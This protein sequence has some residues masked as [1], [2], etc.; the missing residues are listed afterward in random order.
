[1]ENTIIKEKTLIEGGN[2]YES[3]EIEHS[4][5]NSIIAQIG[6]NCKYK[7]VNDLFIDILPQVEAMV[8]EKT[9][10]LHKNN[11][12]GFRTMVDTCVSNVWMYFATRPIDEEGYILVSDKKIEKLEAT[13][14]D[15]VRYKSLDYNRNYSSDSYLN[16]KDLKDKIRYKNI[17]DANPQIRNR[18]MAQ[19]M[20]MSI[21]ELDQ[22][23][24]HMDAPASLDMEYTDGGGSSWT[25]ADSIQSVDNSIDDM[26]CRLD[27]EAGLDETDYRIAESI[28]EGIQQNVIAKE[29]G[30]TPSAINQRIK[31][32]KFQNKIK[33]V[34]AKYVQ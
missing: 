4:F 30:K 34:V 25:L 20:G 29:L 31:N 18:E 11:E 1:M 8:E 7:N 13:V 32:K 33:K 16:K 14:K 23:R 27:L 17:E 21:K 2:F 15:V 6:E 3:Q 24:L 28:I 5:L 10:K 22:L 26:I 19:E 12:Y 9:Q